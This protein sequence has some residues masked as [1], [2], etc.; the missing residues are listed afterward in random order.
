MTDDSIP[1]DVRDFILKHIDSIAQL[2]A[3]LLMRREP[4]SHWTAAS[5][6][7]RLYI[8]ENEAAAIL[9]HLH[10]KSLIVG[11]HRHFRMSAERS[12]PLEVVDR[13]ATLY[14]RHLIPVTNLVHAKP[15][16]IRAFA[17]AFKLRKDR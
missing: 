4:H 10:A 3:L 12:E 2:E 11:D 17:E 15:S 7:G 1:E 14:S 5:I 9:D 13:L 16:S 6:A 8:D